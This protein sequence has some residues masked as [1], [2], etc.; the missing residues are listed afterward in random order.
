[1]KNDEGIYQCEAQYLTQPKVT[2]QAKLDMIGKK[3]L[4]D[5]AAF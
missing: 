5:V 4:S 3:N 2:G 1:M